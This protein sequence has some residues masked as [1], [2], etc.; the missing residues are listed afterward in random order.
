M[1]SECSHIK[2][3]SYWLTFVIICNNYGHWPLLQILVAF[4]MVILRQ[5]FV[6][7]YSFAFKPKVGRSTPAE[8]RKHDSSA[9]SPGIFFPCPDLDLHL[10]SSRWN[11][12]GQVSSI[13]AEPPWLVIGPVTG[14]STDHHHRHLTLT[15]IGS[16]LE[17]SS[18]VSASPATSADVSFVQFAPARPKH[19]HP[20]HRFLGH[21]SF[22][23]LLH[24]SLIDDRQRPL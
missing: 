13:L 14:M 24:W 18:G 4:I 15:W 19:H 9:G 5:W 3:A 17:W 8:C 6:T 20:R 10:R 21:Y 23:F 2:Y 1:N 22:S 7:R 11:D 12:D 16:G